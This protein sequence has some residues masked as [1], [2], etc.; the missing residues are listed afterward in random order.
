MKP[1]ILLIPALLCS[2]AAEEITLHRMHLA[3]GEGWVDYR[4]ERA[5]IEKVPT[6][7][8]KPGS[9]APLS[10]DQAVEIAKRTATG[11]GV[12]E[13]AEMAVTLE[14]TN[15]YEEALLKRLPEKGCCWFYVVEFTEKE[16]EP[17][18][19]VITMGGAVAKPVPGKR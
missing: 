11:S 4:V 13:K 2:V 17:V 9:K 1:W 19:C 15:R 8:P 5:E 3:A 7:E 12:G 14:T 10:R 18:Y 16:R 6:W